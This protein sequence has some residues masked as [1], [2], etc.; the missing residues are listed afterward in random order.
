MMSLHYKDHTYNTGRKLMLKLFNK[1][2]KNCTNI[3][4]IWNGDKERKLKLKF[5]VQ[6]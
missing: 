1:V 5:C 3:I 2:K 6:I 4:E